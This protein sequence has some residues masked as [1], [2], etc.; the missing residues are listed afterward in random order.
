M[1]L[2]EASWRGA[3]ISGPG[4]TVQYHSKETGENATL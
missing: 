4:H 1:C 2:E 3:G